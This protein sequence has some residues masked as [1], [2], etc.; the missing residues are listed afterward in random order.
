MGG[1]PLNLSLIQGVDI[2]GYVAA[3]GDNVDAEHIGE[4]VI[5]RGIMKTLVDYAPDEF[6]VFGLECNGVLRSSPLPPQLKSTP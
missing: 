1:A 5:V 6:W 2:C 4:R 3:V